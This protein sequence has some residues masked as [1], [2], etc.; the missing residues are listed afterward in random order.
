MANS[1]KD[2]LKVLCEA[3]KLFSR[4]FVETIFSNFTQI[5]FTIFF[6]TT[7]IWMSG[8]KIIFELK[9]FG[10][11]LIAFRSFN[12]DITVHK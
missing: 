2:R 11:S 5:I 10:L 6:L 9:L 3:F 1:M 7:I 8:N 4:G 12:V